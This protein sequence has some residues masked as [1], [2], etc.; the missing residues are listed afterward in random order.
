MAKDAQH[1]HLE[2]EPTS[3]QN[4]LE[5]NMAKTRKVTT[6]KMNLTA[7]GKDAKPVKK[8]PKGG[9]FTKKAK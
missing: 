2:T 6:K 5:I 3:A 4:E 1:L 8:D 7:G 9:R